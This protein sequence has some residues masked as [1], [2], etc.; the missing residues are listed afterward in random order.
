MFD[1]APAVVI[2]KIEPATDLPLAHRVISEIGLLLAAHLAIA[3][4]ATAA[5]QLFAA[6]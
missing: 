6:L 3:L 5:V 4:A 2:E 1:T